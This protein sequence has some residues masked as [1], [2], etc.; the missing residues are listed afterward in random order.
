MKILI[1]G[2]AG[3]IGSNLADQLLKE[4]RFS[5]SV[6]GVDNL[7]YGIKEQI[8]NSVEFHQEDI[9]S[10]EI[11]PLF[12]GVDYVFHLAAKNCISDCQAD[13]VETADVNVAGTVNVFEAARRAKVKKVIY[14]ESSAIYEGSQ[15]F[16]TP[17]SEVKPESFYA[18][19]KICENLFAQGYIK[20]F[21]LK[22]V[23]LRYFNVNG[24]IKDY[25]RNINPLMSAIIIKLLKGEPPIIYGDGNK[26]R[27]FVYIEDV[28]AFHIQCMTDPRTD[29]KVFN[30]GGGENYSVLEIY[31]MI[32][33]ILRVKILPI[34]KPNLPGEARN[35][36]ADVTKAK[37]LGWYPSIDIKT[38]LKDM[39]AYIRGEMAR[40]RI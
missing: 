30:I 15:V 12:A 3:F 14:A 7:S 40:G 2:V 28:N 36:L 34:F 23:F 39:I 1:T 11:Y 6:I 25:R 9:R 8:P 26:R 17:E 5:L 31:K 19:S 33:E 29:G 20:Y 37:K 13:P 38:G 21:G 4:N 35:T 22:I 24:P 27:D 16:P 18:V 10:K 32:S